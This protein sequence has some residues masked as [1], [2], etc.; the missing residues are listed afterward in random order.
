MTSKMGRVAVIGLGAYG[1]VTVKNMLEVGFD[2]V[3]Y[4]RNEYIGGLWTVT[5][6][7][8][9]TSVLPTT[10]SNQSKQ[11]K[12]FTDFPF[13]EDVPDYPTG[14]Q[15]QKY[16]EDYADHFQLRPTFRL[17]TTVTGIN[18]SEKG[19]K[20]I[21]SINRPDSNATE[22]EFDK[23]IITNGTFHSPVMPDVPGI[24]EFGGEVI[25]S[26]SFKDPSDFK[27][28][29]VVVVGLSNSA[30][31]TAVE[32]SK[33]AA[34]VYLSHRSG[35]CI[36]PRINAQGKPSDHAETIS[37]NRLVGLIKSISPRLI[38]FLY[39]RAMEKS[40]HD[41]YPTIDPSWNLLPAPPPTH[42]IPIINDHLISLLA[43]KSIHSVPCIASIPSPHTLT[44]SDST[45]LPNIDTLIF[46]TGY[47]ATFSILPPSLDPT[48]HSTP[49]YDAASFGS[50]VR[51]HARLYQGI[52]SPAHPDSL[53]F[54]GP[55]LIISAFTGADVVSQAIAQVFSGAY[56]LPPQPEIEWWCDDHYAYCLAMAHVARAPAGLVKNGEVGQWLN[57]ACGNGINEML[58][59]GWE[60]WTFWWEE[61]E[62]YRLV[63]GGVNTGFLY[64]VFEGRRRRWGGAR[65]AIYRA[66]GREWGGG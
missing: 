22:E 9:R 45:T 39:T 12:S 26:Q 44:L 46:C 60:A 1:I 10:I 23:V 63:V 43:L 35:A 57:D 42:N 40:T 29:N 32:L 24:D 52:F 64:R 18:R 14:A 61:R 49:E 2:V 28:K 5:T 41:T 27:G 48:A 4:D 66:N 17:G 11:R 58:G 55:Y 53:A 50:S 65:E 47:R 33:V 31:D 38:K 16:L 6:D 30:A 36:L 34:N 51:R 59:W 54:I 21:I 7:P 8:G 37:M 15:V 62:L 56:P 13:P 20:W 25:H 19:D 3:G